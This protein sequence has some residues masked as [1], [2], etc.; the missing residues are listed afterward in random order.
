MDID[1]SDLD[2][3]AVIAALYNASR[4]QGLGFLAG[5]A[6]GDMTVDQA[7]VFIDDG[8]TYFEYLQGRV[9]K[10]DISGDALSAGEYD[11]DNG[12]GAAQVV[13]RALRE[14]GDSSNID[15]QRLHDH[16]TATA[17]AVLQGACDDEAM[18]L[19]K[20]AAKPYVR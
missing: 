4:A 13:I 18:E 14:S 6:S 1:I 20:K 15:I 9:M 5:N 10:V 17:A 3:A 12:E 16:G 19:A 8:Q 2:K 11:L 7:R